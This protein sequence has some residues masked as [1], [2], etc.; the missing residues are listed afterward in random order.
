MSDLKDVTD[1]RDLNWTLQL[2]FNEGK[3]RLHLAFYKDDDNTKPP[4]SP[5]KLEPIR[6]V[7]THKDK[8][9]VMVI[10]QNRKKAAS[11][12]IFLL[13]ASNFNTSSDN[14]LRHMDTTLMGD[15]WLAN[16]NKT[17]QELSKMS[18]GQCNEKEQGDEGAVVHL[19]NSDDSDDS[20]GSD[21]SSGSEEAEGEDGKSI[22]VQEKSGVEGRESHRELQGSGERNDFQEEVKKLR[23]SLLDNPYCSSTS[24]ALKVFGLQDRSKMGPYWQV[25][26]LAK[27][28][29]PVYQLVEKIFHIHPDTTKSKFNRLHG[30]TK[31]G[32]KACLEK[33]AR[34]ES[35]AT[36]LKEANASRPKKKGCATCTRKTTQ[37]NK[38]SAE[39]NSEY[40]QDLEQD[41]KT[42]G[43]RNE[44][45][46]EDI[47]TSQ[48][49]ERHTLARM[50]EYAEKEEVLQK[51]IAQK[52]K[53][54]KDQ[55]RVIAKLRKE[56]ESSSKEAKSLEPEAKRQKILTTWDNSAI[57]EGQE[58]GVIYTLPKEQLFYGRVQTMNLEKVKVAFYK[59]T[60]KSISTSVVE[61]TWVDPIYIVDN[62]VQ[63]SKDGSTLS[64]SKAEEMRIKEKTK[65]YWNAAD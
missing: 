26:R 46:M 28:A 20:E 33:L 35:W 42:L 2:I 5:K 38:T 24:V 25:L 21:D 19:D 54:I 60:K 4:S 17:C 34:G 22:M 7:K 52:D 64:L 45:L 53:Q 41:I 8:E 23:L 27:F 36:V 10:L 63:L 12:R 13:K 49:K 48:N 30:L 29:P 44:K 61:R 18:K 37:P 43:E 55:E 39:D 58:V 56:A 51:D 6:K 14:R 65:K 62:H 3:F 32:Y 15:G 16:W 40:I 50:N 9:A 11:S 1:V 59:T 31:E 47:E 57:E